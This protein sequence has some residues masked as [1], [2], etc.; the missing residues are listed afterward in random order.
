MKILAKYILRQDSYYNYYLDQNKVIDIHDNGKISSVRDKKQDE[1]VDVV[2]K[3]LIS[4]AFVNSHSHAFQI[5]MR[6]KADNPKNF[7]DWVKTYLYPSVLALSEKELRRTY[8]KFF[9]ELMRNGISTLGEFH[10]FHHKYRNDFKFDFVFLEEALES[11]IRLS[12]LQSAYDLGAN[13]A[14]KRFYSDT[15]SFIKS[16]NTIEDWFKKNTKE[17]DWSLSVAP[18][19]LHGASREII[20]ESVTWANDKNLKWHIHLAE[21]KDDI[22]FSIEK[23]QRTPLFALDNIL[24]DL[25]N[26]N[27]CL[28]HACW[29]NQ[30]ELNL[31]NERNLNL[32]YNPLTNMYLGDGITKLS[33]MNFQKSKIAIGTDSNNAFNMLQEAKTAELLQRI[34]HLEMG[35]IDPNILYSSITSFSGEL[36]NSPVGKIEEGYFADILEIDIEGMVHDSISN[37]S[38]E[39]ILNHLIFSGFESKFINKMYISGK[40]KDIH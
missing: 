25:L 29:L 7:S 26:S 35:I 16:L 38:I 13:E 30:D 9:K 28:V 20:K 6:G 24:G 12:F 21:Q 19:S 10:Y 18:H 15:N 4:P 14:Q 33:G 8:Q 36:L 17:N 1:E 5:S 23:Y 39:T 27:A 3:G 2:L 40:E 31:F 32:I 37:L 34:N 11:G 22:E